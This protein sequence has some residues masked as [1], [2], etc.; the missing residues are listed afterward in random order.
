MNWHDYLE[1]DLV[2]WSW[3]GTSLLGL[4]F[5]I[6]GTTL[7][8]KKLTLIADTFSHAILPGVVLSTLFLG[9]SPLALL[10]GGWVAG[11]I[12]LSATLF[13]ARYRKLYQDSVF[14]FLSLFFVA[15]GMILSF[16][17]KTSPEILH[18][19]FGQVLSFDRGMTLTALILTALTF[20][21]FFFVR[22][23]WSLWV[24]DPQFLENQPLAG[25]LQKI[26]LFIS[27]SLLITHLT[28]GLNS[29][30][31]FMTVG[32]VVIPALIAQLIFQRLLTRVIG[33]GLIGLVGTFLGFVLSIYF[34]WPLGPSVVVVLSLSYLLIL[35]CKIPQSQKAT[36]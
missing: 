34:D 35:L 30:G 19:L 3:I 12:L 20:I 10:L 21:F 11:F 5:A 1:L 24:I 17:T 23:L 32:L 26:I 29:L 25:R 4:N 15:I 6:I 16:K 22:R 36:T 9:T 18:L 14:A 7:V 2:Y 31:A 27:L 13:L 33:S 8:E 28:F